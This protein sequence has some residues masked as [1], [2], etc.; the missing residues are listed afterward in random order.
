M[1]NNINRSGLFKSRE[2]DVLKIPGATSSYIIDK[3]D[4][5]LEGKPES[6]I[7]HVQMNNNVNL[8]SNTML[9]FSYIIFGRDKFL[10]PEKYQFDN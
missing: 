8:L 6:S 7:V 5:V 10:Q 4:D 2:V 1:F 3:I 9:S